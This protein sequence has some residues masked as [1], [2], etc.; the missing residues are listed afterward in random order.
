VEV[1]GLLV[2]SLPETEMGELGEETAGSV[3]GEG[4]GGAIGEFSRALLL[5]DIGKKPFP[6]EEEEE[7]EDIIRIWLIFPKFMFL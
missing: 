1:V 6:P 5:R 4:D 7:G 3:G 2:E